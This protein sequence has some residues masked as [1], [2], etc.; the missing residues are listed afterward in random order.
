MRFVEK[1][2]CRWP[3]TFPRGARKN[4]FL[5]K[6]KSSLYMSGRLASSA[7]SSFFCSIS[8][9]W[10]IIS[11]SVWRNSKFSAFSASICAYYAFWLNFTNS[12]L[13]GPFAIRFSDT[14]KLL[15][16]G[17]LPSP[18]AFLSSS[19]SLFAS[20]SD[21]LTVFENSLSFCCNFALSFLASSRSARILFRSSSH[22]S[23]SVYLSFSRDPSS[24]W[25]LPISA[26]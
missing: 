24:F 16:M 18:I 23:L 20:I 3:L 14:V 2:C 21:F 5:I 19:L 6:R 11:S 8:L 26:L 12:G 1:W 13:L 25:S 9:N 10:Y 4:C 15:A 7:I 17:I 22:S